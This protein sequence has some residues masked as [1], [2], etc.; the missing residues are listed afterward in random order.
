MFSICGD[1]AFSLPL[2]IFWAYKKVPLKGYISGW[3]LLVAAAAAEELL[4]TLDINQ[5]CKKYYHIYAR[6][7]RPGPSQAQPRNILFGRED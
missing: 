2:E 1:D 3:K 4:K 7:P 5:T 6:L